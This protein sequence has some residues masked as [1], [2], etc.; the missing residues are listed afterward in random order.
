MP[1]R[2]TS[3]DHMESLGAHFATHLT[4]RS[5]FYLQG[6]LGSG[7]TT[8]VRGL[9]RALGH[10][11][12]V[13]SPTYTLVEPYFVAGYQIYH[14][15]LYRITT[16]DELESIGYRDYFD[17][18]GICLLEWP[19]RACGRLPLADVHFTFSINPGG[20][21]VHCRAQTGTGEKQL[22]QV[23]AKIGMADE[24]AP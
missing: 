3:A 20:R 10:G 11:G 1:F 16:P 17:G 13:K 14:F 9:L 23:T 22:W 8:F 19:E 2:I 18:H 7:K 12:K 15:D 21:D 6:Q 24:G 5:L 4:G